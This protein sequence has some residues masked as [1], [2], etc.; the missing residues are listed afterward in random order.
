M[1]EASGFKDL[2]NFKSYWRFFKKGIAIGLLAGLTTWLISFVLS[3]INGGVPIKLDTVAQFGGLSGMI[4]IALTV[5][6]VV[7]GIVAGFLVEFVNNNK[8]AIIKWVNK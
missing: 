4:V 7:Y 8:S 1:T 6:W 3:A 5:A 2:L